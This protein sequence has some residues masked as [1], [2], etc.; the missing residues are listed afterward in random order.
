MDEVQD[1]ATFPDPIS[2][3]T[4]TIGTDRSLDELDSVVRLSGTDE[5]GDV[6]FGPAHFLELGGYEAT[7]L[8]RLIEWSLPQY[9]PGDDPSAT[10]DFQTILS[11]L[12]RL[13]ADKD[14]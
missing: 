13:I 8:A 9:L 2:G 6:M 4:I 5:Q 7:I 3:G 1:F 10:E 14:R 11:R 12:R